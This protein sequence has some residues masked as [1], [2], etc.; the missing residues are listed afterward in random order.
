LVWECMQVLEKLSK[1]IKVTLMCT[2][3]HQGIPG[4][5]EAGWLRKGLLKSHQTSLLLYLL[6]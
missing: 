2:P 3:G 6:A 5:E 4:N 1:F